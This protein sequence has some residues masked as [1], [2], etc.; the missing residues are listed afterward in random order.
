MCDTGEEH[1]PRSETLFTICYTSGTTGIA[2][3]AMITHGN[4]VASIGSAHESDIRLSEED[5]HIS[6]LPLA[7]LMDR[8]VCSYMA[9]I[10]EALVFTVE[11]F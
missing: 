3:G 8:F 11:I 10:G 7:H 6:Y 4:M 2:K 9:G 5:V 1:P